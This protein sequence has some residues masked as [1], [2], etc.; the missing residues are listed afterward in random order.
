V[1]KK[2]KKNREAE[3]DEDGD[4]DCECLHLRGLVRST[5]LRNAKESRLSL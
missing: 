5:A 4:E 1:K 2:K 3:K